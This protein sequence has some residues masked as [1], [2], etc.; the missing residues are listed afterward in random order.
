M[1]L[2]DGPDNISQNE[3]DKGYKDG[4]VQGKLDMEEKSLEKGKT[5]GYEIGNEFGYYKTLINSFNDNLKVFSLNEKS[6]KSFNENKLTLFEKISQVDLESCYKP[7]FEED[8]KRIRNQ[9][10]KVMVILKVTTQSE[11]VNQMDF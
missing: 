11:N 3:W 10:K 2:F 1:E 6:T 5:F 7:E 4:I 9:F 8:I